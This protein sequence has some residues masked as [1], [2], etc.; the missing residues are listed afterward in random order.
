MAG[1]SGT[2][3]TQKLGIQ[4]G[5]TV[6]LTS[7][8]AIFKI[9]A[10]LFFSGMCAL[11]YQTTWL[12]EFRLVFGASTLATATVLAI[13]M[14]GLGA[15]SIVLGKWIDTKSRPL[16]WYARFEFLIA[17]SAATTPALIWLIREIYVGLGGTLALGLHGG[18]VLRL[19]LSSLVL[20][21][22]TFLM[23][24]TLPAAARAAETT[25]DI[26]RRKVAILYGANTCGAV[27][28]VALATFYLFEKL[29]NHRTL[30]L[31]CGLNFIVALLALW[32]AKALPAEE[33]DHSA[34]S[35]EDATGAPMPGSRRSLTP[36]FV[37]VAAALAGFAF[38]L[39]EIVW[40]RMLSPLLGGSTY[41]FGVILAVALLGVGLGGILYALVWRD[42]PATLHG[43]AAVCT[44]ESLCLAIPFG[45]GDRVAVLALLLRPLGTV[46]FYGHVVAWTLISG[47]VVFPAALAAG[48]QF[49]MLIALLGKGNRAVGRHTGLAYAWN[50]VGAICGA[51][52]GGFGLL[53]AL[54][55]PGAWRL[56]VVI[57]AL[58]GLAALA[59]GRSIHR[60]AK[61]VFALG[62][63]VLALAILAAPGPSAVWRH[64]PIGAGRVSPSEMPTLNQLRN[65]MQEQRRIMHWE[66]EGIE[67]SVAV[68][69]DDGFS[70][71]V[72]GKND[73]NTNSDAGTQVMSGLIGAALHPH[74]T[75]TL[76]VG[77]GTGS[78]AGWLAS[79][80]SM[81]RVDVVEFEPAI[82]RVAQLCSPVNRDASQNPKLRTL[83]GDGREVLLT[84]PETYDLI[85]SEPS[86][87]FRAGIASLFTREYY[88][89]ASKRLRDGGMFIQ[90]MQAYE[91][92]TNTIHTAYATLASVFPNIETWETA[93]SDLLFVASMKPI[94]YDA[95]AL[96]SR[97]MTE[98]FRT[99]MISAWR[100]ATLE[101]FLARYVG[102]NALA[103]LSAQ[104]KE[105]RL[106]TDDCT[107][108]E[109]A[110]AR[111]VGSEIGVNT[112]ELRQ[113]ARDAHADRPNIDL[114]QPGWTKVENEKMSMLTW[115]QESQIAQTF[116]TKDQ[117][118]RVEAHRSY[119]Q[120]DFQQAWEQW[121]AT[122]REP[123]TLMELTLVADVL[124]NLGE[125]TALPYIE[126]LRTFCPADADCLL[127]F[128]R[129]QQDRYDDA[130]R[131]LVTAFGQMRINPWTN[132]SL[133][134]R[135]LSCASAVAAEDETKTLAPAFYAALSEPFS[136]YVANE[137]RMRTRL[138][139]ARRL[140]GKD[141]TKY[142]LEAVK[143]F[144]PNV[145][146][147]RDFLTVR[148]ECYQKFAD[149]KARAAQRDLDVFRRAAP[150]TYANSIKPK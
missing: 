66:A 105:V 149:P 106:N 96:R 101:G 130:A 55:A 113:L 79:V 4:P 138:D 6:A 90:W 28:G 147:E 139:M 56:A 140:D 72:N 25:D 60:P 11:I 35:R 19:A 118:E 44:L 63:A 75:R 48:I 127:G 114:E 8:P 67:S 148:S 124:A 45:L 69:H 135:A 22:P 84:T 145:L 34:M 53:P 49:P 142:T 83:I 109:Y 41:T 29:G 26:S 13:F 115:E 23:G 65:W 99:A 95:Q 54:T 51:M 92:D 77:L 43:F 12:R 16:A 133:V 18:T 42:R 30:W 132:D 3:L 14:G 123:E 91:V 50:T 110:F 100:T 122:P 39:M 46:G 126:K 111:T 143:A 21:V 70:F 97:L 74:P 62:A 78:T 98:P 71:L 94:T 108:M 117:N 81:E 146:W 144:E 103:R 150:V 27:A 86:N 116:H 2:P 129:Y 68:T 40:Y 5:A 24:G 47:V 73:G 9:A 125:E 37:L 131:A 38:F 128:L 82:R 31:A 87:P 64:S 137:Q 121:S 32:M 17:L 88:R 36:Y 7:A 20:F 58:L 120:K 59:V 10:L 52:A 102:D 136:V 107:V 1:Y 104:A 33:I 61:S 93:D 89:A 134:E 141:F 80:P 112:E 119:L 85:V 76:V 15:G 57:P